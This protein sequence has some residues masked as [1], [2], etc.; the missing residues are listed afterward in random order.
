MKTRKGFV[1]NSSSSSFVLAGY[2]LSR[3]SVEKVI[4]QDE[5]AFYDI[6]E[7][8]I[9]DGSEDGVGNKVVAGELIIDIDSDDGFIENEI[10]L[11]EDIS[12]RMEA[13]KEKILEYGFEIIGE[14]KLYAGTRMT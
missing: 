1:S 13:V 14:G 8:K 4:K 12:K 2:E 3:E 5:D 9:L 7:F 6:D 11:L 10:M